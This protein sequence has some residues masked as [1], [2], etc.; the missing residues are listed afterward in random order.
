MCS[1]MM[2]KLLQAAALGEQ[3]VSSVVQESSPGSS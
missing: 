3:G 2:D 1:M